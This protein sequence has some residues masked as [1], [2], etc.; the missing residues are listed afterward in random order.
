MEIPCA[1]AAD[2]VLLIVLVHVLLSIGIS[3]GLNNIFFSYFVGIQIMHINGGET[4]G[5]A[6][7][8]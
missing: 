8:G 3:V 4:A 6:M 5:R 2:L 1:L 7:R